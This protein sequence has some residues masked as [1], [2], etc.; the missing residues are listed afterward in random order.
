MHVHTTVTCCRKERLLVYPFTQKD[1][2]VTGMLES[3]REDRAFIAMMVHRLN[4]CALIICRPCICCLYA[5]KLSFAFVSPK[6]S[7]N[8]GAP[9]SPCGRSYG[10]GEEGSVRGRSLGSQN[11]PTTLLP[12]ERSFNF[13]EYTK[14]LLE[15]SSSVCNL[16]LLYN[17]LKKNS[18]PLS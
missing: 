4:T 5:L 10:A 16:I 17:V 18:A 3:K 15:S 1:G 6:F 2:L 7:V 12:G 8:S 9:A 11:T 13:Y 14:V